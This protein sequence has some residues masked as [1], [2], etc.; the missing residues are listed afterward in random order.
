MKVR[1]FDLYYADLS[2]NVVESEQNGVRPVVVIQNDIGNKYSPTVLVIPVTSEIKKISQPTHCILHKTLKNGLKVDSMVMAEQIRVIDKSRLKDKIGYV[3]N[4][5]EQNDI[6][7][8][9]MANIT[10]KKQYD[11]WWSKIIYMVC[12]L[13]K[14]GACRNAA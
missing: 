1:M 4:E 7:N 3:D 5:F 6:I 12:K 2:K 13:V 10:G 11:S 14:E 8:T 9:Y